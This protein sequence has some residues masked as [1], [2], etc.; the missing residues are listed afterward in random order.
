MKLRVATVALSRRRQVLGVLAV[1]LTWLACSATASALTIT[2]VEGTSLSG[3]VAA[4]SPQC[5]N[6]PTFVSATITWGDGS[7]SPGQYTQALASYVVSG[8]HTYARYGSYSGSVSLTLE[9]GGSPLTENG[10]FTASVSDA[11]ISA[12]GVSVN[13]YAGQ[14]LTAPIAHIVDANPD[15]VASDDSATITWG[16]G[17]TSAGTVAAASGGGFNVSG[18][19][20]YG[21][22]GTYSIAVSIVSSGG[23]VASATTTATVTTAPPVITPPPVTTPPTVVLPPAARASFV[24]SAIATAGHVTLDASSSAPAGATASYYDW[25][26]ASAPG[27]D[28]V[29]PASDPDVQLNV[30]AGVSTSVTLATADLVSGARSSVSQE[31][32][33]PSP[34]SAHPSGHGPAVVGLCSG[35]TKPSVPPLRATSLPKGS[36]PPISNA[37]GSPPAGCNQ[38]LVFGAV[39]ARGCFTPL[40]DANDL[41]GGID[42]GLA[43]LLCKAN[44][45]DFCM[46]AGALVSAVKSFAGFAAASPIDQQIK[47]VKGVLS[48]FSFPSYYSY[49]AVRLDGVDIVPQNGTPILILPSVDAFVA[50]QVKVFVDNHLIVPA[51]IPLGLYLPSAGGELATLTLPHELPLIGSLPFSGSISIALQKAHSKLSNGDTCQYACAALTVSAELPGV[52]TGPDGKGLSASGVVTADAVNG[53]QLDSLEIK[54]P[55]AE[56]AGIG[57]EN[58]DVSYHHTNE[59]LHAQATIDLNELGKIGG[60]VDLAHG[61]FQDGD[62]FWD[63]GDGPGIDL[64]GPFNIYLV[65]LEG[66]VSLNPTTIT[67]TGKI[68][69]GP[70]TLGCSLF[71]M[72]GTI[73][74]QFAPFSLDA[75]AQGQLLCQ[76]VADE[77]F[78]IDQSGSIRL[79]GT[80]NIGLLFFQFSGGIEI[81]V[82]TAQ[83]HFQADANMNACVDFEGT[84]CVG[85]EVV[86]SDKG[87]GLCAD[88][89]FTHAG[90]GIIFPDDVVVMFDSC[91]I[92]QFRSL[93]APAFASAAARAFT[94]PKG[95]TV[96]VIGVKGSG[97]APRVTLTGPHGQTIDT[98]PS[99]Y[100]RT[101][102]EFI[103]AD[104]SDSKETYFVIDHMAPGQWKMSLD[105]GSVPIIGIQQGASLPS[106]DVHAS[107]L[108]A[109]HGK[110]VLRYRL[111]PLAGQR[112]AF[113]ERDAR[114]NIYTIG[115]ARGKSGSLSFTPTALL[116][117][118]RTIMAEVT[119]NGHPREDDTLLHYRA[120]TPAPLPAPAGLRAKRAAGTLRARWKRVTGAEAYAVTVELSDHSMRFV[121]VKATSAT[122]TDFPA[123]IG[124]TVDVKAIR[125]STTQ[126]YGL[127]A[128]TTV[129]ANKRLRIVRVAPE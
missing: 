7:D 103:V 39:D 67:A 17:S 62:V 107:L 45:A 119:Q 113:I 9:C 93:P 124:A 40:P 2:S 30:R 108:R 29:C 12:T 49:S 50:P 74:T 71:S 127:V 115:A 117:L 3:M 46:A 14:S 27:Q 116:G 72:T 60:Y 95:Q 109:R 51:T 58:V 37:G 89:G 20:T 97:G 94:V 16:D 11:P 66:S 24:I 15:G 54:V 23:S 91:D 126:R 110:F 31:I 81:A 43:G 125:K 65:H 79:G 32:T 34:K 1:A 57:V 128:H 98:P 73:T 5:S 69:G 70:Q 100:E 78:H 129:K 82:D 92:S 106:P 41:P 84:H 77:Y 68:T 8:A 96:S 122:V 47:V 59:A 48:E 19:H 61:D 75:N 44:D 38:N 101:A 111:H 63:A 102:H 76:N 22:T 18:A 114:G 118:K 55:S 120:P 33:I 36:R 121:Q 52:F 56:I 88:L 90:G 10:T 21:S 87:I 42:V 83:G 86:L 112:V 35:P 6:T 26:L 104:D 85:A 123:G 4:L 80:V 105:P 28:V 99:G 25:T 13:A 53:L 64:G